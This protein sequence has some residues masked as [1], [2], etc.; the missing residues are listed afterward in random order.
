MGY[1]F[2]VKMG[3]LSHFSR[4]LRRTRQKF[5]IVYFDVLRYEETATLRSPLSPGIATPC[6][7]LHNTY[8]L[9]SL[10]RRTRKHRSKFVILE[11]SVVNLH[12]QVG[13][14]RR[15]RCPKS[16]IEGSFELKPWFWGSP[17]LEDLRFFACVLSPSLISDFGHC[18][19]T[20]WYL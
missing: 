19:A 4:S 17:I 7:N 12:G 8:L 11:Q 13:S 9:I 18:S 14:F 10:E 20:R 16:K 15:F 6:M 2:Q 1:K 3:I 5:N